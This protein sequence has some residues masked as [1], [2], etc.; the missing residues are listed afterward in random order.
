MIIW[1]M[2]Y[3]FEHID[4]GVMCCKSCEWL[5]NC[6]R[7][8]IIM[9]SR[10]RSWDDKIHLVSFPKWTEINSTGGDVSLVGSA[11]KTARWERRRSRCHLIFQWND[12]PNTTQSL[13]LSHGSF[14]GIYISF[15]FIYSIYLCLWIHPEWDTPNESTVNVK[16]P[17]FLV[18]L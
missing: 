14:T 5:K 17:I 1:N 7:S 2:E 16:K 3:Q 15:S 10:S 4:F 12:F 8:M 6:A 9:I 11:R 18:N 13:G